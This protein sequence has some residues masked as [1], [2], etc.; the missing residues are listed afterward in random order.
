MPSCTGRR[1]NTRHIHPKIPSH[2]TERKEENGDER[3]DEYSSAIIILQRLH[4]LHILNRERL[5]PLFQV[6]AGRLLQS[7]PTQDPLDRF[8]FVVEFQPPSSVVF[9]ERIGINGVAEFQ[10]Y[11]FLLIEHVLYDSD[12]FLEGIEHL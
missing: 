8:A 10:N 4:Q 6:R 1:I 3:E 9:G 12:F 2:E 7:K 5:C 11:F